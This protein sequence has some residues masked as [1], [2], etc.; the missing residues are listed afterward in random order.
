MSAFNDPAFMTGGSGMSAA[1][2]NAAAAIRD[3]SVDPKLEYRT[4]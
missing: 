3:Y 4:I 2:I 1:Q